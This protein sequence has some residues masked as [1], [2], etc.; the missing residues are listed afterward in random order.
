MEERLQVRVYAENN[1]TTFWLYRMSANK[2]LAWKS[3]L[4][5][6]IGSG[7]A[8]VIY[9]LMKMLIALIALFY[10]GGNTCTKLI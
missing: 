5:V 2:A 8:I 3:Y 4:W 10:F 6:K 9:L 1:T 7:N